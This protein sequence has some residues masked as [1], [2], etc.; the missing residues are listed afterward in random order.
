MATEIDE[1]IVIGGREYSRVEDMP[2]HVRAI[3]EKT[4]ELLLDRDQDGIPDA[5]KGKG[6]GGFVQ[7]ARELWKVAHSA[8]SGAPAGS[9]R[10]ELSS[11]APS[12]RGREAESL[13]TSSI[14][15]WL[16]LLLL[17]T[18][19]AIFAVVQLDLLP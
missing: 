16:P 15:T 4:K 19:A 18:A 2:P 7:I 17:L 9:R 1:K 3:Y 11:T 8:R 6:L 5:L 13:G 10:G 14:G 12:A